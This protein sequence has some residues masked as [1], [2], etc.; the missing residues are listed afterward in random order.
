ML[1][2]GEKSARAAGQQTPGEDGDGPPLEVDASRPFKEVKAEVV[3]RFERSY[4]EQVLDRT[5]GNISAAAREA[6]IDRKH[7][8]R[9]IRK[10]G[11]EVKNR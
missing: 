2:R 9:L 5:R 10:H 7:M 1:A 4:L 6:G 8:E 11:I 3:S